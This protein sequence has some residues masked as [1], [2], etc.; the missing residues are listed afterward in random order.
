[1]ASPTATLKRLLL[2][3]PFRSDRLQHTLLP[4]RI[5]LPIF[6]SDPLSSVAYAPGEILLT[7]SL[8]GAAAYSYAPWIAVAVAVVLGTVVFL[9]L[10]YCAY[11]GSH[12]ALT[13]VTG[14]LPGRIAAGVRA[15]A[16][17]LVAVLLVW[18][19]WATGI[20][21]LDSFQTGEYK[22]GLAQWPLWPARTTIV[23]GLALTLPVYVV[24]VWDNLQIARGRKPVPVNRA[25]DGAHVV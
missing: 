13:L 22:F 25:E 23:V 2:G 6:A 8:A 5:A 15:A 10:G 17:T 7:L 16:Y 3:R 19:L 21:A 1:M 4:K 11:S 9:A 18:M 20:R 12:I 14:A 24:G